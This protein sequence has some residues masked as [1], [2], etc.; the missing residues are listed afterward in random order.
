MMDDDDM[1]YNIF[2]MA[3]SLIGWQQAFKFMIIN[4]EA[5]TPISLSTNPD[6]GK[7]FRQLN[8]LSVL[9]REK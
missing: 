2:R 5:G 6:L 8:Q 9:S 7:Y 1:A 4:N 3:V